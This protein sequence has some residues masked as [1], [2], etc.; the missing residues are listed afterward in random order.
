[1]NWIERFF[2]RAKHW[3]I[4]LLFLILGIVSE[5]PVLGNFAAAKSPEG[6]GTVLLMTEFATAVAAWCFIL[7]LWSLGS[8]LN[9]IVPAALRPGKKFFLFAVVYSAA[10]V[11]ASMALFQ[12]IDLK[13]FVATI[14]LS[15]LALFCMFYNLYFVAKNLVTAET[16]KLATF[17]DNAG[18][19]MLVWFS[20]IG[21]WLIQPRVNRLYAAKRSAEAA[22]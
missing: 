7:W 16:D 3:Q 9:S 11:P 14:P 10:Y 15:L 20:L 8:F 13:L 12:S 17:Y 19:F 21:V 22:A 1:M 18:P 6:Y 4:F 5:F 2:V